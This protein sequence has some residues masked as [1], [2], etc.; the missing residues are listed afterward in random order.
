MF[1]MT[2][3]GFDCQQGK[4]R[5]MQTWLRDNQAKLAKAAPAG[6]EYVGTFSTVLDSEKGANYRQVWKHS[7][8]G[9][10]DAWA[11]AMREGGDFAKI[12]DEFTTTFID[13]GREAHWSNT[14]LKAVTDTSIWGQG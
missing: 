4:S 9:D 7:S 1:F 3:I 6:W 11:A 14:T 13:E 5:E 2:E 12:Y 10:M 8:Y